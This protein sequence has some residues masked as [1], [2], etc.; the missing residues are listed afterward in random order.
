MDSRHVLIV[1]DSEADFLL[2]QEA[3]SRVGVPV[4][5]HHVA[6]GHQCLQ[7][8]RRTGGYRDAPRPDLLVVDVNMPV[9][10]GR[11]LARELSSDPKLKGLPM[12]V[13]STS[14]SERDVRDMYQLGCNAYLPK[15][16]DFNEF[17]GLLKR[18]S[19]YWF[20]DVLLPSAYAES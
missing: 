14:K 3:F 4:K 1:D 20:S 17:V 5:V 10:D 2:A 6:H 8:L 15:P 9:M 16:V 13:L 18:A 7:F 11:A 12:L 19:A